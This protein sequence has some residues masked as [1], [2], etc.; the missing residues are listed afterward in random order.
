MGLRVMI[1][2]AS[3]SLGTLFREF[4]AAHRVTLVSRSPLIVMQNEKWIQAG[5][6][7]DPGWWADFQ[8]DGE[9]D[10]VIHL[11]EPVKREMSD[12]E[13]DRVVL[14]HNNFIAAAIGISPSVV[15]PL[16]AYRYD[17][18]LCRKA[19]TYTAIKERV[20]L[21]NKHRTG[22]SFP[23]FHP[24]I[25]YGDGIHST[26]KFERKI[27]FFNLFCD[28]DLELPVLYK[29]T[30][31]SYLFSPMA[32]GV[33]DVYTKIDRISNIFNAGRRLNIVAL[34]RLIKL[35]LNALSFVYAFEL[36]THGRKLAQPTNFVKFGD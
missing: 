35:T 19:A 32:D 30:I 7:L 27:P 28:F 2:G 5:D 3:G 21:A 15:Y 33:K 1:T 8:F 24:L 31:K 25:D 9:Y 22:L 26:I 6:L 18:R 10:R 11:A 34:S 14:S 12:D 36:L 13:V 4:Y 16:T 17:R 29:A 20:L 23:I